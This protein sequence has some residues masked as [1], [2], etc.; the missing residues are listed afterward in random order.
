MRLPSFHLRIAV[1]YSWQNIR[2]TKPNLNIIKRSEKH[3]EE[4]IEEM[5]DTAVSTAET[6]EITYEGVT[7]W[8]TV[9]SS[10]LFWI[11]NDMKKDI[12]LM[13]DVWILNCSVIILSMG[14]ECWARSQ[15]CHPQYEHLSQSVWINLSWR[16]PWLIL[17]RLR[18][19]LILNRNRNQQKYRSQMI[20]PIDRIKEICTVFIIKILPVKRNW[21]LHYHN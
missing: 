2:V 18:I 17:R 15:G 16:Y 19:F 14:S 13:W 21:Y 9:T 20:L 4:K 1:L 7:S 8:D 11:W 6:I 12:S 5:M 3:L 10:W